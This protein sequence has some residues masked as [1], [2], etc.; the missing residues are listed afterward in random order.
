MLPFLVVYLH[1]V[2]GFALSDVGCCSRWRRWSASWWSAAGTVIDRLGARVVV[3]VRSRSRSRP[4]C[5]SPSPTNPPGDDRRHAARRGV[6]RLLARL[7]GLI[8]T[9]VP[10]E[11]RQRY[12][13]VNLTLLILG[14]GIGGL[15]AGFFVDVD[16]LATFQT[17]YLVDAVSYLPALFLLLVPLRHVAGRPEHFGD[18][19]PPQE[20]YLAVYPTAGGRLAAGAELRV[21]VRRLLAAQRR[22]AAAY[23]RSV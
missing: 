17:I 23:A 19:A 14:I 20:G 4:T 3:V 1:E 10:S 21:V 5:C 7:A 18:S 11:L 8:A 12:F 2:R 22:H 6:R 9:A 13:G 16:S 15:I